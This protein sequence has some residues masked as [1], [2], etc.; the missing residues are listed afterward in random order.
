[1]L[2]SSDGS[3]N[4]LPRV[5]CGVIFTGGMRREPAKDSISSAVAAVE[6]GGHL[7]LKSNW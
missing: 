5:V 7:P 1:M 4:S 2:S 6:V 3:G